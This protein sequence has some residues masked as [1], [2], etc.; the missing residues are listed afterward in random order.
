MGKFYTG[1]GVLFTPE[2]Q[3]AYTWYFIGFFICIS[4]QNKQTKIWFVFW[5]KVAF[6]CIIFKYKNFYFFLSFLI[7]KLKRYFTSLMNELQILKIY[8]FDIQ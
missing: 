2:I 5:I 7:I 4:K 1:S 8:I 6:V 3:E